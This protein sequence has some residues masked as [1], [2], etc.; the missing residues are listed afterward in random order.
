MAFDPDFILTVGGKDVTKYCQELIVVDDEEG[1]SSLTATL[2]N[3]D[4]VNS[5]LAV[6]GDTIALRFG[7]QGS[8]SGKIEFP[9]QPFGEAYPTDG[10]LTVTYTGYD[11]Q[12]KLNRGKMKGNFDEDM[13]LTEAAQ[14]IV[15]S[16]GL[17]TDPNMK[18]P[19]FEKT[20]IPIPNMTKQQAADTCRKACKRDGEG[21]SK[22]GGKSP[23]KGEQKKVAKFNGEVGLGLA[24]SGAGN[25]PFHQKDGERLD[26]GREYNDHQAAEGEPV[27]A[28]LEIIGEPGLRAKATVQI[29]GVGPVSSGNYYAKK[30]EQRWT[31]GD[32]Y[33]TEADL[34]RSGT[35]KGENK[36]QPLVQ[37]AEIYDNNKI[38]M[39]PRKVD[40]TPQRSFT[41]NY[42]KGKP[43]IGFWLS[44]NPQ[45][46]RG[47]GESGQGQIDTV[48]LRKRAEAIVAKDDS[49]KGGT[50]GGQ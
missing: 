47:G 33:H 20:P 22:K 12:E 1:M 19:K 21:S 4:M 37:Y 15:E 38:Y 14:K 40:Q 36:G 35:G 41:Y 28:R 17:Q 10:N 3:P 45:D 30:V 46:R 44:V 48:D 39:G 6:T 13:D 29:L 8:M 2:A 25:I 23:I 7:Y 49:D 16:E 5:G 43:V 27:T 9:I 31:P 32:G 24:R 34:I 11:P 42:G 50:G 26:E 18:S